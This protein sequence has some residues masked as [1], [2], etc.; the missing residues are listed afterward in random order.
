MATQIIKQRVCDI[1]GG[2]E[3]IRT[4]R[5]GVIGEGR[6]VTPDLCAEHQ[7]PL[8]SIMAAVPNGRTGTG[9]KKQPK[10]KTEAEVKK[11]RKKP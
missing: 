10:V 2:R 7:E 11:L 6:G 4:Y 1:C 5:V 3:G 8:E 9:L